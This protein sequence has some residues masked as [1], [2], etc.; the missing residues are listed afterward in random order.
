VARRNILIART[1]QKIE[2]ND[3]NGAQELLR[4]LD[5]LPGKP[6]FTL[7]LS[8]AARLLR[9]DDAMMQ[10]KIDQLFAATQTLMTQFLDLKPI[11]ELH[12]EFR[13]AQQKAPLKSGKT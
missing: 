10:R 13:E 7:T 3:F 2:K 4:S 6:Q 9:S 1:R 11:S 12:N 8:T 5:D